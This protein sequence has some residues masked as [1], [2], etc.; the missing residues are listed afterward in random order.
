M[1]APIYAMAV[2]LSNLRNTKKCG[3]FDRLSPPFECIKPVTSLGAK[4]DREGVARPGHSPSRPT[5]TLVTHA[6]E[7]KRG[8]KG[9]LLGSDGW[10]LLM[11][12]KLFYRAKGPGSEGSGS[13][14]LLGF[15][16]VKV[17]CVWKKEHCTTESTL[18]C[19]AIWLHDRS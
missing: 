9:V 14:M 10:C 12:R 8:T 3:A 6:R 16:G 17:V 7:K 18:K 2:C 5:L 19:V 4:G 1:H 13:C 11:P 15:I